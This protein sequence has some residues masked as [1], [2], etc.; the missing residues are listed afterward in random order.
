MTNIYDEYLE[1]ITWNETD[2]QRKV[3]VDTDYPNSPCFAVM[4]ESFEFTGLTDS[5]ETCDTV[6]FDARWSSCIRTNLPS[7]GDDASY[8][9][10]GGEDETNW[11]GE[12]DVVWERFN[13]PVVRSLNAGAF[14]IGP[15]GVD[16]SVLQLVFHKDQYHFGVGSGDNCFIIKFQCPPITP[17]PPLANIWMWKFL[18]LTQNTAS[19]ADWIANGKGYYVAFDSVG[20]FPAFVLRHYDNATG[21][22]TL[23]SNIL[24]APMPDN[25]PYVLCVIVSNGTIDVYLEQAGVL[26]P[27]VIRLTAN[28]PGLPAAQR[29]YYGT[30]GFQSSHIAAQPITQTHG[31]EIMHFNI[32]GR[33]MDYDIPGATVG[34]SRFTWAAEGVWPVPLDWVDKETLYYVYRANDNEVTTNFSS[35][36][37]CRTKA[38]I[39][40]WNIGMGAGIDTSYR[41]FT[42]TN[43]KPLC[44]IKHPKLALFGTQVNIDAGE[45]FD[46]ENGHILIAIDVGDGSQIRVIRT[47]YNHPMTFAQYFEVSNPI[48]GGHDAGQGFLIKGLC[49]D[50]AGLVS[51]EV[52]SRIWVTP[53]FCLTEV[54]YA[55]LSPFEKVSKD[56]PNNG[57]S[58]SPAPYLGED[59][60][61]STFG[62]SRSWQIAGKH[63]VSGPNKTGN[64]VNVLSDMVMYEH[65]LFDLLRKYGVIF[66]LVLGNGETV[67]GFIESYEADFTHSPTVIEYT[68]RFSEYAKP[69]KAF[70]RDVII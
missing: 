44:I 46:P 17:N 24:L 27:Y 3:L 33:P 61:M 29:S 38:G 30:C 19:Y 64:P 6:L 21:I 16:S 20:G 58:R 45:S 60:I 7:S 42:V 22:V 15:D 43:K 51:D 41:L 70:T 53:G 18:F 10:A 40:A 11:V 35:I 67:R 69:W 52:S 32:Y 57:Y 1:L 56:I 47:E 39:Q 13:G 14:L 55:P 65:L 54:T 28:I 63:V 8:V 12:W 9:T 66:R 36:I 37:D 50:K 25:T 2:F 48:D 5:L 34:F 31:A 26:Y 68:M 23:L 4:K 49:F 62:G 59:V